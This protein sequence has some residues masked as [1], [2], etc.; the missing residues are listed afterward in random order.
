MKLIE[1]ARR[2]QARRHR[3]LVRA[4]VATLVVAASGIVAYDLGGGPA[5]RV[6]SSRS[7]S[8]TTAA[9]SKGAA[10]QRAQ[11]LSSNMP[12]CFRSS[13]ASPP[14]L[15]TVATA[16]TTVDA[17]PS[18]IG[19]PFAVQVSRHGQWSFVSVAGYTSGVEVFSDRAGAPHWVREI[20]LPPALTGTQGA[21]G[22]AMT[23]DGKYLLV[24]AGHGAAVIDVARAESGA[25]HA[26]L[27]ML[28]DP[29]L[30]DP[31]LVAV[32]PNDR[33][34]FVTSP[35]GGGVAVFDLAKALAHGFGPSDVL[36][37]ESIVAPQ[38]VA[39][40]PDGHW[41]YVTSY[42]GSLEL[43]NL[44]RPSPGHGGLG[45]FEARSITTSGCFLN[46]VVTSANGSLVW[47]TSSDN[48]EL[49]GFSATK[50]VSGP[51]K[52]LVATVQVGDY[53]G[54]LTLFDH[55]Q[56]VAVADGDWGAF[57]SGYPGPPPGAASNLVVVNVKAALAHRPALLGAVPTG[58]WPRSITAT[59]DGSKLFV[60]NSVSVQ[61]E[62]INAKDAAR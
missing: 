19:R 50:L 3:L 52:A 29:S 30:A 58:E 14:V 49:L 61:L 33:Y 22:E 32:S 10:A 6:P 48:N 13:F 59:A 35:L 15:D 43:V 1:E 55:G 26:L 34:V 42:P 47:V 51:A 8:S 12:S 36:G 44:R 46:R 57:T 41:L 40:S 38:D 37:V 7:G 18:A 31:W 24:A 28:S 39:V 5:P 23:R 60:V 2:R 11:L 27:G 54:G 16:S 53:P 62:V 20:V 17:Y 9:S 4:G 21:K 45:P 25:P 56:R